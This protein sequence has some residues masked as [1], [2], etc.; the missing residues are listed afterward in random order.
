MGF[1]QEVID[2]IGVD[3]YDKLVAVAND[4]VTAAMQMNLQDQWG[5]DQYY[6]MRFLVQELIE[7]YRL[8]QE[9]RLTISPED[10]VNILFKCKLLHA[11]SDEREYNKRA[12]ASSWVDEVNFIV[13]WHRK[14]EDVDSL[15]SEYFDKLKSFQKERTLVTTMNAFYQMSKTQQIFFDDLFSALDL[16]FLAY[17][18]ETTLDVKRKVLDRYYRNDNV[19]EAKKFFAWPSIGYKCFGSE[20]Y[21]RW[22]STHF[23]RTF[24]DLLK[25]SGFI[26]PGQRE[27]GASDVEIMAP[28]HSVFLGTGS[29]GAYMWD[30]DQKDLWAKIPDGCMVR[31]FGYR[32]I[33]KLWLDQ[34]N[35]EK[36]KSFFIE[37]KIIF[38]HLKNPWSRVCIKD[39]IPTI[40][41]LA[42]A[43]RVQDLGAKVLLLYCTLEHLF[44]PEKEIK[45]NNEF[46]LGGINALDSK[47]ISWYKTLYQQRCNYAHKG[48]VKETKNQLKIFIESSFQNI[49]QLLALKISK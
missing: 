21:C 16:P 22:Q 14:S 8:F 25:I 37:Y 27:F 13:P 5:A 11:V 6:K 39:I 7:E 20:P 17:L 12:G 30:E 1:Q 24:L 23:L 15:V 48:Y 26:Y 19:D 31:S 4:E 34:R 43:T 2:I 47:L 33:S 3:S 18:D 32:G 46:I 35:F 28:Q 42:S 45:H 10:I 36:I 44:V 49:I 29:M 38:D 9:R 40:D 41:I